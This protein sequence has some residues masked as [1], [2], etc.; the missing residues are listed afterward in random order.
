M[1]VSTFNDLNEHAG[2]HVEVNQY[3]NKETGEVLNVAVECMDCNCV[4]FD[5][6]KDPD[7]DYS[8]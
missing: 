2:H 7:P 5:F 8:D 3:V 4:L 1:A 6:E